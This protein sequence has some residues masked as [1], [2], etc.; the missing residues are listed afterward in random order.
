MSESWFVAATAAISIYCVVQ[1]V[2][3]F[4]RRN[5]ILAGL[6]LA[7]LVVFLTAPI[8]TH[9]VRYDVPKANHAN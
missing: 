5:Y 9:A 8:E 1:I 3:D 4:R 2:R 7:C 6:G